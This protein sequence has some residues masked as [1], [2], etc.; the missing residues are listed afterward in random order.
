[1]SDESK[2]QQAAEQ[3]AKTVAEV[4]KEAEE[5]A[6]NAADKLKKKMSKNKKATIA[7]AVVAVIA[8]LG[9]GFWTWHMSPT[10]CNFLC[11]SPQDN[12]VAS[13]YSGDKGKGVTVHANAGKN[14]LSCH[15][16]TLVTQM[17]EGIIWVADGFK[18]TEDGYLQTGH[19]LA[20]KEFC[21]RSGCHNWEGV[22]KATWGFEGN[23]EKYNPH[24]SHQD[25]SIT[26]SDC[27]KIHQTSQLYCAKCHTL[28][29]PEGWE[30]T[31]E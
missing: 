8:V 12:Y 3:T 23:D 19:D 20:T 31:S 4:E 18:M 21:T 5:K 26:C 28:T 14:C 17:Q 13:Y 1:M 2:A 16:A 30:A 10:F 9:A 15:E 6:E 25:G 7:V 22:V 11:H 29:L 24:V 27:H